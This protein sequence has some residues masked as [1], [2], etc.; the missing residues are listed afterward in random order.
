M[1]FKL[2]Y[3][4]NMFSTTMYFLLI[5][6]ILYGRPAFCISQVKQTLAPFLSL[7]FPFLCSSVGWRGQKL[8][9][10]R[11]GP[12]GAV[13]VGITA[14]LH[15]SKVQLMDT[16]QGCVWGALYCRFILCAPA[17]TLPAQRQPCPLTFT[18]LKVTN[19]WLK[20]YL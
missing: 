10:K 5:M 8:K 6:S 19:S 4:N 12:Q 15:L 7:L 16:S 20:S 9:E 1:H 11:A 13:L 18:Q 2:N 17:P 3:F 14:A